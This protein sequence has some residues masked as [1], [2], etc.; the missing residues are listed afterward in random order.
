MSTSAVA[1]V[2]TALYSLGIGLLQVL[3][4]LAAAAEA[5]KRWGE[6]SSKLP[7]IGP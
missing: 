3:G 5:F 2:V 4:G 1:I 7:T 6:A